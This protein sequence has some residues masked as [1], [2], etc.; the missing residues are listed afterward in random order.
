MRVLLGSAVLGA[1]MEL[2]QHVQP[3][4]DFERAVINALGE[5]S[6]DE[7]VEAINKHRASPSA[8]GES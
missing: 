5:I 8:S 3:R 4:D 6:W 2:D 1:R 7:A